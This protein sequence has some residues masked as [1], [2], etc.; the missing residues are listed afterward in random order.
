MANHAFYTRKLTLA[1]LYEMYLKECINLKQEPMSF[2]EFS[3]SVEE[4]ER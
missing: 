4:Q 3:K 2:Q 1:E